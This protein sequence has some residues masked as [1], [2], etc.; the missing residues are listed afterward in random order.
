M[1][2]TPAIATGAGVSALLTLVQIEHWL[3]IVVGVLTIAV[4]LSRLVINL[5]DLWHGRTSN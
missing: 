4:L 1:N 2:D 3:G 5:R